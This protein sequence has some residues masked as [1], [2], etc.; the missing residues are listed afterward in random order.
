VVASEG[1]SARLLSLGVYD[2]SSNGSATWC[3]MA[4]C[5]GRVK[6]NTYRRRR[7]DAARG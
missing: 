2:R 5:G 1:L 3:S 7:E 6:A 4:V